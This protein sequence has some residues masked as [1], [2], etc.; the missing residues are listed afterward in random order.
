M[1]PLEPNAVPVAAATSSE[2]NSR[3]SKTL[4]AI[5]NPQWGNVAPERNVI[6]RRVAKP[7]QLPIKDNRA[8]IAD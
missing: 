4:V 7:R 3:K 6:P 8:A 2:R 1:A 5:S